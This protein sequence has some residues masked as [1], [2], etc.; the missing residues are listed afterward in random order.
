MDKPTVGS[1]VF[2]PDSKPEV[3]TLPKDAV[4]LPP[5]DHFRTDTVQADAIAELRA[6]LVEG[7][8][9]ARAI[10]FV[11]CTCIDAY[12]LR[13]RSAPDCPR[14]NLDM[15]AGDWVRLNTWL[16]KWGK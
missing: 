15:E 10:S 14:C 5:G 4:L 2:A 1:V 13:G 7:R 12:K 8:E 3:P 11:P 16:S 6:A 9:W